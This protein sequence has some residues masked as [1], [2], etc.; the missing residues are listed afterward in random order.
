MSI[1]NCVDGVYFIEIN[2]GQKRSVFKL[3]LRK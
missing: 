1:E 2:I 3:V